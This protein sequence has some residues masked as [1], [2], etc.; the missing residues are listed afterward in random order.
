MKTG[1]AFRWKV[2]WLIN[3]AGEGLILSDLIDDSSLQTS[4]L[5]VT[6]RDF[7]QNAPR[8]LASRTQN[9]QVL[10]FLKMN[11]DLLLDS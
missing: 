3:E 7:Y 1:T 11:L 6:T 2:N 5:H 10:Y 4:I 8:K 9:Y